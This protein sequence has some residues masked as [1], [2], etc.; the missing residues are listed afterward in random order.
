M[1]SARHAG[2]RVAKTRIYARVDRDRQCVVYSMHLASAEDV[3]MILPVPVVAASP[4]SAMTF[5]DLS[6]YPTLFDDLAAYFAPPMQGFGPPS[7]RLAPEQAATLVVHEVGVFVASFVP[8]LADFAR[9]DPRFQLPEAVWSQLPQYADWG[10][11]VFQLARGDAKV[12]PMAFHF[13]TRDP[14]R[15]F[16]PTMHVHDGQVHERAAFDHELYWQGPQVGHITDQTSFG[17]LSPVSGQRSQG[18]LLQDVARR[19]VMRGEF[20]NT[21]VWIG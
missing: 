21:D 11:A 1:F 18:L 7:R 16:F 2:L 19:R 6:G 20:A 10:F 8:T 4:E 5:V 13:P 17:P 14:S 3:A 15:V 9:L 12:H